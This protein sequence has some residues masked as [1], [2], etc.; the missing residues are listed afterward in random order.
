MICSG[1]V[2]AKLGTVYFTSK[3]KG[4]VR[5]KSY[6][7]NIQQKNIGIHP[8]FHVLGQKNILCVDREGEFIFPQ[9]EKR[10]GEKGC[11]CLF[12]HKKNISSRPMDSAEAERN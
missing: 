3:K 12:P 10:K 4:K 8:I 6:F 2:S 1:F 11:G 5:N 9:K 7:C